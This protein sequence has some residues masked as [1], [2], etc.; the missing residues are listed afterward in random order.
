MVEWKSSCWWNT[1]SAAPRLQVNIRQDVEVLE[2]KGLLGPPLQQYIFYR[3]FPF[4]E[5]Q[6][7]Y[8]GHEQ[9][10]LFFK[11]FSVLKYMVRCSS[12]TQY[13]ALR[14]SS[15][16]C[17]LNRVHYVFTLWL[18]VSTHK[19]KELV[20]IYSSHILYLEIAWHVNLSWCG[21]LLSGNVTGTGLI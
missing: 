11:S 19:I 7:P 5:D 14:A 17:K 4:K 1:H 16:V 18:I 8:P 21:Q 20:L 10:H 13:E 9:E 15:D 3:F 6:L 12:I 2:F